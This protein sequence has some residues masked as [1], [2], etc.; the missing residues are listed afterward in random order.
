MEPR[1]GDRILEDHGEKTIVTPYNGAPHNFGPA[2]SRR[3]CLV[4]T[5]ERPGGDTKGEKISTR[6]KVDEW[7]KF[8]TSPHRNIK[9]VFILLG[10]DELEAY[11]EPGLIQAYTDC[12]ITPHHIPYAS[13]NSFARIMTEL[14]KIESLKENSVVHCTHGMGRSGR[15][16]AGWL[17]HHYGLPLPEAVEETLVAARDHGVERMGSPLQ[18]EK[19]IGS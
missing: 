1:E 3:D 5:S 4:N 10:D 11:K 18:L 19:W 2:S 8:M 7:V 9:H 12:G 14:D 17:V 6:Q 16:A 15:V 13:E